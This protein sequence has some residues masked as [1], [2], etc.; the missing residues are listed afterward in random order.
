MTARDVYDAVGIELNKAK[1]PTILLEDFNYFFNKSI[2]QSVNKF[3]NSYD[4]S[5]QTTDDIRVL[6]S[7]AEL[8]PEKIRETTGLDL[9]GAA[10]EVYL[11]PDYFHILNAVCKF[12]PTKNFKCYKSG[13][14][15]YFGARR[16]VADSWPVIIT[17]LYNRPS[18]KM[19]YYYLHNVNKLNTNL[20]S[21]NSYETEDKIALGT[22]TDNQLARSMTVEGSK[23]AL[24]T[25]IPKGCTAAITLQAEVGGLTGNSITLSFL[26][27]TPLSTLISTWNAANTANKV[28]LLSGDAAQVPTENIVLSGGAATNSISL[29][30]SEKE[31]AYR[32]GNASSVRMEIRYGKDASIFNLDKI[33]VDY[34][35]NPQYIVLTEEQIDAT[36]DTSQMMEFPDYIIYE[37]INNLITLILENTSNPRLQTNIPISQSIAPAEQQIELQQVKEQLR[38]M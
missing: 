14:P 31:A 24:Y 12:V 21:N 26:A 10:Y 38:N 37:V 1:A 28:V 4:V 35:K 25:G 33:Y 19:P 23:K 8:I 29:A 30:N 15:V 36:L 7:S 20:L 16:L 18:Y 3:Y 9:F 17:N 22:G 5:Q 34:L 32:Y 2:S 27:T 6:K 13:I 11:P